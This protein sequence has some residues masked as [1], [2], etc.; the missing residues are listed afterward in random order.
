MP[1][2]VRNLADLPNGSRVFIDTNIFD[3]H[4]RGKSLT[5]T[6][7]LAGVER[8]EIVGFVNVKVL[9]DLLHKL[10]LAEAVKGSF[11]TKPQ[12]SQL[13]A[14]LR[15]DRTR[16]ASLTQHHG[17]FKTVLK[18]RMQIIE[19]N[20]TVL[21]SSRTS[22]EQWGL[23]TGDSLHLTCMSRA[24]PAIT[25]IVTHDGDFEHIDGL[26]VWKPQDVV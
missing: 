6:N 26:T 3:L 2:T 24:K 25:D 15:A 11:I 22:R 9:Y 7:F 18:Y 20:G 13:K 8:R 23:L 12:A 4:F 1:A 5:C 10:M 19:L 17:L 21:R 16:I 14:W